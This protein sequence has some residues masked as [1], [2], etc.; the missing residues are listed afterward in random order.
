MDEAMDQN[1]KR[2][3]PK[4]SQINDFFA[5]Q[6]SQTHP[7]LRPKFQRELDHKTYSRLT[8]GNDVSLLPN[9]HS[10]SVKLGLIKSAKKSIYIATFQIVCDDGGKLFAKGLVKAMK[11]GVD[12]RFLVTGGP[13]TWAFSG[14]CTESMRLKG[15]NVGTMPYSYITNYGVV[16]LHDKIFIV[17]NKTAIVGGQNIGSWYSKQ[18]EGNVRFRDTDAVVSGP[19]VLDILTRFASLWRSAEPNDPVPI[20][21]IIRPQTQQYAEWLNQKPL[22]GLCRFISQTP[23]KEE[24]WV[25]EGYKLYA[26]RAKRRAI[27][28]SLSLNAYGSP[29][30]ENLWNAFN[31]ISENPNGEVFLITNGPGFIRSRPEGSPEWVGR[32]MGYYFLSSVYDSLYDTKIQA[33]VYPSWL[34]SKV[35]FFDNLAVGIGSFNFDETG[36]I[37]TESTMIC[38]DDNLREA[39]IRMFKQDLKRSY[40]LRNP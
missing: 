1:Q 8:A 16:Q 37:W 10:A 6:P 40:V 19:V 11:R 32:I 14:T 26:Q 38:L 2:E 21:K 3:H 9:A 31:S 12:V 27:F 36:L 5:Y 29:E 33:F 34:H 35:Y 13:W 25:F 20:K 7:Y 22:K 23:S 18:D 4:P 24:F 28:H 15:V 17:D 30:Q 39:A